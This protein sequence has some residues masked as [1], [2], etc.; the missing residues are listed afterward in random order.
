MQANQLEK[1]R[2]GK[3]FIAALDQSGGSTPKALAGYGVSEDAYSNEEEMFDLVHEMRT[4]IITSPAF[5]S[6]HI[7]GAI[8]F[9]QTMDRE[10]EGQ[11]TADYL[12]EKKGIVPFLKVDKGLADAS[13]G[14]Q[15]MKP[16]HDLDETLR[17]ANER[18]IFGTKMR[19]VIKEANPEGI[20]TVVDQQFEIGKQIIE[21]GLVPIIEPEV[22]IHSNDKE[23][24]EQI[25]KDE[26]LG[27]LNNL[28]DKDNVM[29]KLSIPTVANTYK[30]L[31]DHPRVVRV[32]ALS[33]G[34]SR[35]EANEKL[36][37]NDGL[38]ASFSRAL[39]ADLN[40]NQTDE[41]FNAALRDAVESIY[42]A[43][44]NKK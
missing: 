30:E 39:S 12:A 26:I 8:L 25:L 42:D 7:L 32:V 16:I 2:K 34:Y 23:K 33:G 29:L 15:L 18:H 31:I 11:Y 20:K 27:H 10:I 1:I 19:S 37:E 14:V 6:T 35:D 5:D 44:V 4:R 43:S 40:V 36:K 9:E 21:A 22:D 3:G 24:S 13:N 17:R 41:E 38:I 28:D